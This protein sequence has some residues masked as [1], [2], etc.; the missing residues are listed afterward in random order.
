MEKFS[1]DQVIYNYAS[2]IWDI[3]RTPIVNEILE[4]VRKEYSDVQLF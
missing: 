3:E 4:K 2:S 1:S